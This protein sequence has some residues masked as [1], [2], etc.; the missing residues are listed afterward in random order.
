ME[1]V[2]LTV[3]RTARYYLLSD[4]SE[5]V[6]EVWL[7][8]HGY[9][10]LAQYFIQH[11]K[12][13]LRPGVLIV[14]PEGLSRFYL[15]GLSGRVGASWMTREDRLNEIQD[16]VDYLSQVYQHVCEEKAIAGHRL[17]VL[18]FS[19]GVPTVC[20]WMAETNFKVDALICWAGFFPHDMIWNTDMKNRF[21][22][23]VYMVYGNEDIYIE[24][25]SLNK[26]HEFKKQLQLNT[27]DVVFSGGHSLQKDT[28]LRIVNELRNI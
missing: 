21:A 10:Q 27:R 22:M 20:R 12:T 28:L 26:L 13:L 4:E 8:A 2:H 9:G 25:D 15:Y 6:T 23:P 11:F 14:S 18:G 3:K 7:V 24:K 17:Y 1:E 16:Y 5:P 19:Q